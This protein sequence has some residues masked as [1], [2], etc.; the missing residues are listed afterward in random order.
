MAKKAHVGETAEAD[1][2]APEGTE[3]TAQHVKDH[4]EAMREAHERLGL[5]TDDL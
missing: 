2:I 3:I 4:Q 1:D 5:P